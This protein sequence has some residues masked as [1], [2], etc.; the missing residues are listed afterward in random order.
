MLRLLQA[1]TGQAARCFWLGPPAE[2]AAPHPLTEC[3]AGVAAVRDDALGNIGRYV[4][5][6][7]R[8]RQLVGLPRRQGS[9]A[10]EEGHADRHTALLRQ[11]RQALP[12]V[13]PQLPRAEFGRDGSP[14]YPVVATPDDRLRFLAIWHLR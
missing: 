7:G 11:L 3:V 4:Q 5:Q 13:Q 2:P 9:R 14:L 6:S 8:K 1:Q 12:Y 10:V